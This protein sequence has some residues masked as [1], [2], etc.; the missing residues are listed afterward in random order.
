M[1]VSVCRRGAT[2]SRTSRCFVGKVRQRPV[3]TRGSS[4]ACEDALATRTGSRE[5]KLPCCGEVVW[6]RIDGCDLIGWPMAFG[7]SRIWFFFFS[8]LFTTLV[9]RVG[10]KAY[11][12]IKTEQSMGA[13][14]AV[15]L[16]T[17]SQCGDGAS[18]SLDWPSGAMGSACDP[19]FPG[20]AILARGQACHP[21]LEPSRTI[22]VLLRG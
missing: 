20:N 16:P 21:S 22:K 19:S 9:E 18:A 2:S 3:P 12:A 7:R 15:L 6:R 14:A 17:A 11:L 10:V 8:L 1:P 4:T 5:D 13:T